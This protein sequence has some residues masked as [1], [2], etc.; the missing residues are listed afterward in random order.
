MRVTDI[1][2]GG[3]TPAEIQSYYEQDF[4]EQ[5]LIEAMTSIGQTYTHGAHY[6]PRGH[7]HVT[8]IRVDHMGA[9]RRWFVERLMHA[10]GWI[11]KPDPSAP[12]WST[13]ENR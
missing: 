1:D 6:G 12:S 2:T 10:L 13:D 3:P 4:A 8:A 7:H 5:E 9:I 11:A